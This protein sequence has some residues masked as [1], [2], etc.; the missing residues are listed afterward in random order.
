MSADPLAELPS[1]ATTSGSRS[2]EE[3]LLRLAIENARSV[4]RIDAKGFVESV[5]RG[6]PLDPDARETWA[7]IGWLHDQKD[8]DLFR[9][10]R[11]LELVIAIY[12]QVAD[13]EDG[14]FSSQEMVRWK[15]NLIATM[16]DLQKQLSKEII[17]WQRRRNNGS[18]T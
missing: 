17:S 7:R 18:T 2:P 1:M 13:L 8:P 10:H 12:S 15:E 16:N 11:S 4:C 5:L 14:I 9:D 3:H 6:F